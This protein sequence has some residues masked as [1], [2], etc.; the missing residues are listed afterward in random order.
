MRRLTSFLLVLVLAA[1]IHVDWHFARPTH[2]RLS[3]G[4]SSHWV[5]CVLIFAAAGWF[6]TRLWPADRWRAA[7]WNVML[8]LV[9]AQFVEPVLEALIYEHRLAYDVE[10][11]RW[12][13]FWTCVATGIPGLIAA[14]LGIRSRS[15]R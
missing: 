8:A 10:P 4:W 14:L 5:F 11:E 6:I 3:L 12:R 15:N 13:V 9:A 2:H 7:A 1:L